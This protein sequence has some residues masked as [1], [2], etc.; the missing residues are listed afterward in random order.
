M[1]GSSRQSS[2][3]SAETP[4]LPN[5]RR[6]TSPGGS[7]EARGDGSRPHALAPR[8]GLSRYQQRSAPYRLRRS[9]PRRRRCWSRALCELMSLSS[10]EPSSFLRRTMR[11]ELST[12]ASHRLREPAIGLN[13]KP[14]SSWSAAS[15]RIA[16]S[17]LAR[18]LTAVDKLCGISPLPASGR[19]VDAHRAPSV[20]P[21]PPTPPRGAHP[22]LRPSGRE[23]AGV[24]SAGGSAARGADRGWGFPAARLAASSRRR[25]R[26]HSR[27]QQP[28]DRVLPGIARVL[29]TAR[30][31]Q[32]R[33][34][35]GVPPEQVP[36]PP[37]R[38][39]DA[40]VRRG[41]HLRAP[42]S[43]RA[44]ARRTRGVLRGARRD[45][46]EPRS[47]RRRHWRVGRLRR[48]RHTRSGT[49]S[50]NREAAASCT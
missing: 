4:R 43:P 36:R 1:V 48:C 17:T 6:E 33:R 16:S 22:V 37:A 40:G 3:R 23:P 35:G 38:P 45:S 41:A 31:R 30:D 7:G 8:P 39:R 50:S 24:D 14:A 21:P 25:A 27:G 42:A 28:S 46:A 12:R 32:R 10:K 29:P 47:P 20:S 13:R 5:P 15:L 19:S 18:L 49:R 34:A 26:D 9:I 44:L 2:L 11:P